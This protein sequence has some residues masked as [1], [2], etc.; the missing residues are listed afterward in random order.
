MAL[1]QWDNSLSVS[2]AEI[3]K[4]HQQLV[5]RINELNDAMKLG[6]GKDALGKILNALIDYTAT[7]FKTEEKYFDLYKY[8]DTALHK[9]E[10]V[11]FVQKVSDFKD[12][13]D[14]GKLSITIELMNFLSDWLKNH[15]KGTDKKYSAFFSSKG[16]K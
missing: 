2:V 11:A 12:G 7:H 3:D 9:K 5:S 10:H 14:K 6:K 15:I 16:L 4:Q 1:I 8:P 13:F